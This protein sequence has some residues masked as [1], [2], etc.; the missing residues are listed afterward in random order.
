MQ[1]RRLGVFLVGAAIAGFSAGADPAGGHGGGDPAAEIAG[2]GSAANEEENFLWPYAQNGVSYK[3]LRADLL[4]Y[5]ND[6][7]DNREPVDEVTL[8]AMGEVLENK[9]EALRQ[10]CNGAQDAHGHPM[11]DDA[12][13]IED[14]DLADGDKIA[15]A[16]AMLGKRSLEQYQAMRDATRPTR[17][18][19]EGDRQFHKTRRTQV[20]Q[21]VLALMASPDARL[22]R[23]SVI[24]FW[25]RERLHPADPTVFLRG[26]LPGAD[27]EPSASAMV[28]DFFGG[29]TTDFYDQ[30]IPLLEAGTKCSR[31]VRQCHCRVSLFLNIS[32]QDALSPVGNTVYGSTPKGYQATFYDETGKVMPLGRNEQPKQSAYSADGDGYIDFWTQGK[33]PLRV[34][35]DMQD[36]LKGRIPKNSVGRQI[37]QMCARLFNLPEAEGMRRCTQTGAA[38]GGCQPDPPETAEQRR[39]R[40]AAAANVDPLAQQRLK[41]P[42]T[43]AFSPETDVPVWDLKPPKTC[44]WKGTLAKDDGKLADDAN[45]PKQLFWMKFKGTPATQATNRAVE[46]FV[47]LYQSVQNPSLSIGQK[48]LMFALFQELADGPHG[49][50][51]MPEFE[52][53]RFLPNRMGMFRSAEDI[54]RA[55][56][57]L[58]GQAAAQRDRFRKAID[59]YNDQVDKAKVQDLGSLD[60]ALADVV[61]ALSKSPTSHETEDEL[62]PKLAKVHYPGGVSEDNPDYYRYPRG[63]PSRGWDVAL[64]GQQG[65]LE[66]LHRLEISA[67]GKDLFGVQDAC[68]AGGKCVEVTA[69]INDADEISGGEL[70]PVT[71]PISGVLNIVN[72]ASAGDAFK[73]AIDYYSAG[74]RIC[75]KLD[76]KGID[77]FKAGDPRSTTFTELGRCCHKAIDSCLKACTPVSYGPWGDGAGAFFSGI[78]VVGFGIDLVHSDWNPSERLKDNAKECVKCTHEA[79]EKLEGTEILRG[80]GHVLC[81]F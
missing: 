4:K 74:A 80:G 67:D 52:L 17:E 12:G 13:T 58:A 50:Q 55:R 56:D 54:Q 81:E 59:A 32:G 5:F 68:A 65:A 14:A 21:D 78:P 22:P 35:R 15:Q 53:Y 66:K 30:L 72:S 29:P 28:P 47:C 3:N 43:S 41:D 36:G 33:I 77:A 75:S 6:R 44:D 10:V 61:N 38:S 9:L 20:S 2:H 26:P 23:E 40:E 63:T 64:A 76:D 73:K 51:N 19:V 7:R 60:P 70:N 25:T 69:L 18:D 45:D 48:E 62:L 49:F 16:K 37:F 57:F 8:Q 24:D 46:R 42:S 39:A 27:P 11:Q 79:M 1:G 31:P 34:C 71:A